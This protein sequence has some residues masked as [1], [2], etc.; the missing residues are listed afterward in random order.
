MIK[1]VDLK[2]FKPFVKELIAYYYDLP[3]K[4]AG[5]CLHIVLDDGNTDLHCINYCQE[6]CEQK[7]DTFGYFL[8]DVLM[9]F[10]EE[11]LDKLYEKDFWGMHT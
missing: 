10:T 5:G 4:A 1:K 11:E 6:V 8:C 2:I 9:E 3:D 7:D